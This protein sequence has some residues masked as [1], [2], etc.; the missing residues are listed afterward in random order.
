MKRITYSPHLKF[1]L[2]LR[3]IPYLL[4]IEIYKTS[5]EQYFDTVTKNLVA[6]KKLVYK[7]KSREIML[8]YTENSIEI[9]LITIHPL[10]TE[11]KFNRIRSNR[12]QKL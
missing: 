9:T 6:V 5:K 1:R 2:K 7:G 10:K 11:Q 3:K 8:A 12:W 4:P